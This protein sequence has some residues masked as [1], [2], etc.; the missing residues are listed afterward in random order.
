MHLYDGQLKPVS[1]GGVSIFPALV[2]G[3]RTDVSMKHSNLTC[4][5]VVKGARKNLVIDDFKITA[6]N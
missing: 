4:E 2:D 5:M 1:I 6:L 3:E